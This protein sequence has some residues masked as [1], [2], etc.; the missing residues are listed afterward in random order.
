MKQPQP[1]INWEEKLKIVLESTTSEHLILI[2]CSTVHLE[3][4]HAFPSPL[5]L[6]ESVC[7]APHL[8]S[9]DATRL[10][11]GK[12]LKEDVALSGVSL[13]SNQGDVI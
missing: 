9:S 10:L 2:Y 7:Q 13:V 5:L 8:L 11:R 6:T 4:L 1:A 3:S 12:L